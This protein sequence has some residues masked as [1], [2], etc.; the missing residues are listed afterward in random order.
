MKCIKRTYVTF[1]LLTYVSLMNAFSAATLKVN[2]T[3]SIR[4]ATH[5]ASGALYGITESLPSDIP[6]QVAALKGNVYVQPA[7]SGQGHQQGIGDALAVAKRLQGT[8]GKVQIRLADILPGWPYKW[9][10]QQNWL[11]SVRDLINKKLSSGLNNFD[12][13]EIWNEPYGTW[14]NNNG[15]FHST[16]WKP[17][18]QLIKQMDPKAKII[19]PSFAFYS[20]SRMET[21]LK[22]CKENNCMPDVICWHQWG[23]DGF[24]GALENLR[25]LEKKY[26]LKE[27]PI[28]INEYSSTTHEYEGCPGYSVPFIAKFERNK[29]ESA[30]ISWWFTGLPGRLG[31]LLTAKNERGG[32]WWLYKWYGDMTGYMARV[33]P[34][35]DRSEGVDGFAAVDKRQNY[36]SIVLG[37]KTVDNINVV[38]EKLPQFLGGKVRVKVERVVWKDKDTPVASTNLISESDVVIN[39]TSLTI[40]VKI[41]SEFY[42]YRIYLTPLDVPQIPY[43]NNVVSIPGKIEAE[44]YDEAGQGFSYYDNDTENKGNSY[45]NDGV[46]VVTAPSGYALGYTEKGEWVEYTVNVEETNEYTITSNVANSAELDGFQLFID[47]KAITEEYTIP[48]TCDDWSTYEEVE[49]GI[50]RLEKGQHILKLQIV[51]SYVNIDWIKFETYDPTGVNEVFNTNS[52]EDVR[53]FDLYGRQLS[54]SDLQKN[55]IYVIVSPDNSENHKFIKKQ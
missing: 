17:T 44:N 1:A 5:C 32:G 39:G 38:F 28:S 27:H 37:G 3:D 47:D 29:V 8:T 4:P 7:M 10:G 26:G 25:S 49:V 9:P 21:F 42:A 36:A 33:T 24:I 20:S 34:P 35:N 45:R 16:L 40:P 48:K 54:E 50:V 18:Y 55:K 15:D 41:E 46:D 53:Y 52:Y 13:Y 30:M 2:L 43:Q 19:G 14:Q 11:N 12:G 22:Y 6:N 23:S 51:G 31:S